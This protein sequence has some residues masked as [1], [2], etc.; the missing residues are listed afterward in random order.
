MKNLCLDEHFITVNFESIW[1][2][3]V[4]DSQLILLML[5]SISYLYLLSRLESFRLP[6]EYCV[7]LSNP[8]SFSSLMAARMKKNMHNGLK[9]FFFAYFGSR[10]DQH[11]SIA[12]VIYGLSTNVMIN[13]SK[14]FFSNWPITVVRTS[15]VF[16]SNYQWK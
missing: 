7:M 11:R 6:D 14:V 5:P 16:M 3:P 9:C 10:F 4:R 15:I 1:I 13:Q 12:H 8:Q 2:L